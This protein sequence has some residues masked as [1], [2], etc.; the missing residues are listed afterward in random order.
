METLQP[1]DPQRKCF[2]LI[3]GV[4]V[5]HTVKDVLPALKINKENV[6]END[7]SHSSRFAIIIE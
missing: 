1:L 6:R 4:L 5:E 7:E 3:G 2:R